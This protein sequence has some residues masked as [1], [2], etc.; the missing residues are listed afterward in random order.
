MKTVKGANW[1]GDRRGIWSTPARWPALIVVGSCVSSAALAGSLSGRVA[2]GVKSLRSA[3]VEIVELQRR[4]QTGSD[5]LFRFGDVPDGMYT[6]RTHYVGALALETKVTVSGDTRGVAIQLEGVADDA[7]RGP[8]RRDRV[9]HRPVPRDQ[10]PALRRYC[11]RS[12]GVGG[13]Y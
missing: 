2:A 12:C 9:S 10:C 5:G 13:E 7:V 4:T 6:L 11:N 3:E 8:R 1:R